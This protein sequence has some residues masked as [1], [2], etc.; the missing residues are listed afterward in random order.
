MAE[1]DAA[2]LTLAVAPEARNLGV[3]TLLLE[4]LAVLAARRDV[5]DLVGAALVDNEPLLRVFR[6]TGLEF[7]E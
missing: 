2:A 7:H 6:R 1:R 5:R 4:R 3:G